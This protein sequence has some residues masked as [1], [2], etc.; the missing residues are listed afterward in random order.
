M[1][2]GS[3]SFASAFIDDDGAPQRSYGDC[4][5]DPV[6]GVDDAPFTWQRY[7]NKRVEDLKGIG[8]T[9]NQHHQV[10]TGSWP[11]KNASGNSFT[12]WNEPDD[13]N[14]MSNPSPDDYRRC[15]WGR[16]FVWLPELI[17][18]RFFPRARMPCKWH[19]GCYDCVCVKDKLNTRGPRMVVDSEGV[20]FV[21]SGKYECLE[22]KRNG[23]HP[24]HFN[25]YDRDVLGQLP[26]HICR[27]FPALLTR[28]SAISLNVMRDMISSVMH[29]M[30]FSAF[31]SKLY[32]FHRELDAELEL[33]HASFKDFIRKQE[34]QGV[35]ALEGQSIHP[36]KHAEMMYTSSRHRAR[37][38][39]VSWFIQRFHEW[40][41]PRADWFDRQMMMCDGEELC[42]DKS[43]KI[44]RLTFTRL[45]IDD[46]ASQAFDGIFTLMSGQKR[47]VGQWFVL[48][49]SLE[50]VEIALAG[51]AERYKLYG[52][53]GPLLY[54]TDD[55]CH[56]HAML[57]RV[58]R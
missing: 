16:L 18:R 44:T 37:F 7:F 28:R 47:I 25:G 53:R 49:S 24:Y 21:W 1:P 14:Q 26:P 41:D 4:D 51:V 3:V 15:Q 19:K 9:G 54:H 32:E 35:V 27:L 31:R 2:A 45:S 57:V 5:D 58:F 23:Q 55:C 30:N 11:W 46:T 38:P 13:P 56:E 48:S 10:V 52:F 36:Y 39:S 22:R 12:M 34:R 40:V 8:R 42:G 20:F 6:S 29:K 50:E 33:D 17:Y 43:H